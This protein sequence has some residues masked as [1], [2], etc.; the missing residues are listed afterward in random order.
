MK[1]PHLENAYVPEAKIVKYLLNQEHRQGGKE[2]SVFF[3]RFGF[4]IDAWE[5]LAQALLAHAAAHEIASTFEKPGVT[6]FAI[7]GAL[8]TPDNRQP[9][10][11]TIW[12]LEEDSEA[13]RFVTAYPLLRRNQY[14]PGI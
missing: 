12:A 6:N 9:L 8:D 5:D 4:T 7:E 10:V 1:L 13:P 11:R 2:K 14:D 3:M